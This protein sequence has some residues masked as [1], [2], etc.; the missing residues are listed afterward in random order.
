[1]LSQRG[2]IV[3]SDRRLAS[4]LANHDRDRVLLKRRIV[5]R[6]PTQAQIEGLPVERK[7]V[8]AGESEHSR[9]FHRPVRESCADSLSAV[10]W[11]HQNT[12]QPRRE[13]R[14]RI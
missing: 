10:L 4:K 9:F 13:M 2:T 7:K 1:M 12:R 6:R 8:G 14:V 11:I 5:Q 3:G